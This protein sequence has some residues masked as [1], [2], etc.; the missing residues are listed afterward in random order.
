ML[1]IPPQACY[2]V[3]SLLRKSTQTQILDMQY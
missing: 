1:R 2:D 3:H